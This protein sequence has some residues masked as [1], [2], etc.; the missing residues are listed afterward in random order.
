MIVLVAI[1]IILVGLV[2]VARG[3]FTEALS[4]SPLTRATLVGM[5]VI[6]LGAGFLIG[7]LL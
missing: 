4:G 1:L 2:V 3:L 7:A 6:A 5:C